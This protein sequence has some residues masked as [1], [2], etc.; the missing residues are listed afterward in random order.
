MNDSNSRTTDDVLAL[1]RRWDR[2]IWTALPGLPFGP[3]RYW[4]ARYRDEC[5]AGA[6]GAGVGLS[7]C[8]PIRFVPAGRRQGPRRARARTEWHS[9]ARPHPPP[10][11]RFQR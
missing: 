3:L 2:F 9:Y 11:L 8:R 4:V 1:A 6:G 10:R 7:V 5:R